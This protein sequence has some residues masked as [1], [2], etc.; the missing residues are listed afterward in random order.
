MYLALLLALT[1]LTFQTPDQGVPLK[2]NVAKT[3]EEK[4]NG[5]QRKEEL[6]EDEGM[7]FVF[8]KEGFYPFWMKDTYFSLALIFVNSDYKIVDIRYGKA[9]SKKII[10]SKNPYQYVIEARPSFIMKNKIRHG[11]YLENF[12]KQID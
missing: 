7:L 3:D 8:E 4:M 2:V 11:M 6:P 10:K 1:T 5:L 12:E 9:E